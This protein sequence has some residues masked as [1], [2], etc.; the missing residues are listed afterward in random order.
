MDVMP[1][2]N[3]GDNIC[4]AEHGQDKTYRRTGGHDGSEEGN[5]NN[6]GADTGGFAESDGDSGGDDDE[7]GYG[8]KFKHEIKI[9]G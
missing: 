2:V 5:E 6:Q 7:P 4:E 8:I 1:P 3:D 9:R